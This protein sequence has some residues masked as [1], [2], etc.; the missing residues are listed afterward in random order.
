M[1]ETYGTLLIVIVVLDGEPRGGDDPA[2]AERHVIRIIRGPD[3]DLT[4]FTVRKAFAFQDVVE[5]C[6]VTSYWSA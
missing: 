4:D 6:A 5:V 1:S 2:P 3:L